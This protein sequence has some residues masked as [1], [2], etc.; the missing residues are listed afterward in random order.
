MSVNVWLAGAVIVLTA[1][2][3][4]ADR[5]G[6]GPANAR[7][8][9]WVETAGAVIVTEHQSASLRP[10]DPGDD[11][12]VITAMAIDPFGN[13]L[14]V[15]G[16]D[17]I[18]R[19]LDPRTLQTSGRM[20]AAHTDRIRSMAYGA[21]G[22]LITGGNDGRLLVWTPD[23]QLARR[24]DNTPPIATLRFD[25]AGDRLAAVGFDSGVYLLGSAADREPIVRCDCA[26]L[27]GLAFSSDG[28]Q[29]AV[30]GR[31][32]CVHLIDTADGSELR[33]EISPT[34]R[35]GDL[36]FDGESSILFVVGE[37]GCVTRI[38]VDSRRV[39]SRSRLTTGR[40]VCVAMIG[41]ETIAAAGSD[42]V[43]WLLQFS[44][45]PGDPGRVIAQ[46]VGHRGSVEAMAVGDNQLFSGGFD[47]VVRR[48]DLDVAMRRSF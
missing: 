17:Q 27:R 3:G 22:R 31:D 11:A 6:G 39:L 36:A 33:V 44:P 14:A 40:L 45:V 47:A 26:D 18:I 15:A 1:V 41:S 10:I 32:G 8:V 25:P 20:P 28:R 23:G 38:D 21:S 13:R 24:Y 5:P 9:P 37:D 30:G 34:G 29:L 7:D 35:V 19:H 12:V 46:L 4:R 48:W 42:D 2:S 16:D 43:V